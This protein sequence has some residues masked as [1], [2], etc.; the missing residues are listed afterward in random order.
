MVL[1]AAPTAAL[2]VE[3]LPRTT[4]P[5]KPAATVTLLP[6]TNALS[7]AMLLSLPSE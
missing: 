4:A 5:F 1:P 7:E 3:L 6:M 2:T